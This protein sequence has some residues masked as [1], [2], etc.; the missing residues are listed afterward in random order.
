MSM[1][2]ERV[3][4]QILKTLAD[5]QFHSGE[6]LGERLG[7]SRAAISKHIK[8]FSALGLDIFSVTGKGYKLASPL[9]LLD[10]AQ[11]AMHCQRGD[12][13]PLEV[14]NIIDSTNE[15]LKSKLSGLQQGHSCIAEAQT[16]GR[17]RHG[18]KWV[19]PYG[20]SL[21]L[22]T[23]W[24]FTGGYQAVA[25]LSLAVGVAV[26]EALQK[27]GIEGVQLKWPNDIYLDSKKLAG[28]LIEVEGQMGAACD[29]V[30]GIGL[31][32]DLPVNMTEIDQP[33]TDLKRASGQ[34]HDRNQLCAHLL[35]QLLTM[36]SD[37]EQSGL[38]SFIDRW[39]QL[40]VYRDKDIKLLYGQKSILGIGRG[41]NQQGGILVE[42]EGELK[43]YYGGEI[44]VR[45][46]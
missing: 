31:N 36:L 22:S 15:Y 1:A 28:V 33:W 12:S 14:L 23:Y 11:I 4:N 7:I 29:C 5:G 18:R 17:G 9:K 6:V 34:E 42:H 40:D 30:I 41:I 25:G 19:S 37:F 43:A 44:S 46:A 32:I 2:T 39:R 10:R 27:V 38:Q 35:D 16:A 21:Y 3:R 20:S 26:A 24:S 13:F 8:S 45:P